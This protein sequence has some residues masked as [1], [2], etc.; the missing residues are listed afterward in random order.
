VPEG[1]YIVCL[2]RQG[3]QNP[4]VVGP[5][6][7]EYS[8]MT[9]ADSR[10]AA[11]HGQGLLADGLDAG[12]AR[13]LVGS[14]RQEGVECFAVRQSVAP[15]LEAATR[16]HRLRLAAD[17]LEMCLTMRDRTVSVPWAALAAG[18]CTM[19][20]ERKQRK[21]T[22]KDTV[23]MPGGGVVTVKK[24][25]RSQSQP[26]E[27]TVNIALRNS[28]GH[29]RAFEFGRQTPDYACLGD[30]M[31][32][33]RTVNFER[34]LQELARRAPH[35]EFTAG[36]LAMAGGNRRDVPRVNSAARRLRH[37]RWA[38]CCGARSGRDE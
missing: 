6:V 34:F 31:A 1:R 28:Q 36:Y 5:L 19:T 21:Q 2:A 25:E 24:H 29:V 3:K 8:G 38:L 7:Q 32:A 12:R 4:L 18:I 22:Y 15:P 14:L 20:E 33:T 37:L 13:S 27:V 17:G 23:Y 11:M 30:R 10:Q 9:R 26:E 35:A 16:M